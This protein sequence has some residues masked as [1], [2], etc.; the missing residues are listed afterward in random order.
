MSYIA[1]AKGPDKSNCGSQFEE[2]LST[3]TKKVGQQ[4]HEVTGH[5]AS[6]TRRRVLCSAHFLLFIQF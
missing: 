1:V 4:E 6:T 2:M 3:R 5:I